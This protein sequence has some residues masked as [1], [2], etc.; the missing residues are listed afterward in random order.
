MTLNV[1]ERR[2]YRQRALSAVQNSWASCYFWFRFWCVASFA[3]PDF[4]SLI[5][6]GCTAELPYSDSLDWL[7]PFSGAP[8]PGSFSEMSGRNC[9][10]PKLKGQYSIIGT[11]E[12]VL[13]FRYIAPFRNEGDSNATAVKN[14]GYISESFTRCKII[15][16][17]GEI[18]EW[19]F[20]A[21]L[22]T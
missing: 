8:F 12:F 20:H 2:S 17:D 6:R 9:S 11:P 21:R 3:D 10:L 13:D 14:W 19:Y 7:G 16:M 5:N 22:K 1:L 18:S 4:T 15:R